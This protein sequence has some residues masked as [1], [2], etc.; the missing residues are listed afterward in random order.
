LV[1]VSFGLKLFYS[2]TVQKPEIRT[3]LI[4]NFLAKIPVTSGGKTSHTNKE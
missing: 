2:N 1:E 3:E 4:C